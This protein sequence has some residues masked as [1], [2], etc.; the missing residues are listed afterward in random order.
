L[1][2]PVIYID[3]RFLVHATED[4]E[5]VM[6]ALGHVLPVKYINEIGFKRR[7]VQGHYGNPIFFFQTRT[8]KREI[9][10][11]V[12]EKLSSGL[13]AREKE[14]LRAEVHRHLEKGSFYLRLDKQA[15]VQGELKL[16]ASD[17]IH[18]HIRFRNKKPEDIIAVCESLGVLL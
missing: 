9:I 1:K 6:D 5:K 8:R 11:A 10:E 7:K 18:F 13:G 16:S 4:V 12:I 15:A 3:I 2:I 14:R 17:P